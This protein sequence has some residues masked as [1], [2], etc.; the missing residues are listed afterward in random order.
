MAITKKLGRPPGR[1]NNPNRAP[2]PFKTTDAMRAI[3][4]ARNE[5]VEIGRIEIEARSGRITIVP[6]EPLPAKR[7]KELA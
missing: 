6:A 5:G 4:A 1:K 7:E 2:L 3:R